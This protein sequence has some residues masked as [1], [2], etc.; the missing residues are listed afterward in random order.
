[1]P[2]TPPIPNMR[3]G[4]D[5][6]YRAFLAPIRALHATSSQQGPNTAP[7]FIERTTPPL[8]Y[9]LASN[10][11]RQQRRVG[12]PSAQR[13]ARRPYRNPAA[14]ATTRMAPVAV[15]ASAMPIEKNGKTSLVSTLPV[16]VWTEGDAIRRIPT[17]QRLR[18]YAHRR[19]DPAFRWSNNQVLVLRHW[20]AFP[21]L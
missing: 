6:R 18:D 19:A 21:H 17:S 12:N 7:S 14:A 10:A 3:A 5:E 20:G 9:V 4:S 15:Q 16:G 2:R 8:P 11:L 13:A 1:M